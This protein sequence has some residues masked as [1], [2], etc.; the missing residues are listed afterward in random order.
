MIFAVSAILSICIHCYTIISSQQYIGE[1]V[2]SFLPYLILIATVFS[3]VSWYYVWYAWYKRAP[4]RKILWWTVVV[5]LHALIVKYYSELLIDQYP[6]IISQNQTPTLSGY[7]FLYANIYYKNENYSWLL[8]TIDQYQPDM[9]LLVEYAKQHDEVISP[10]LKQRYPYVSRYVGG[11]GYDGDVIYSKHKLTTIKH[12]SYPWSFSHVSITLNQKTIDFALI[13]TSAP[14][15]Y[16]FFQMR[17]DQLGLLSWLI[18][19]Y[20]QENSNLSNTTILLWDFNISPWSAY[21]HPFDQAM[22]QLGLQDISSDLTKTQYISK[23]PYTRCHE[24]MPIACSHIDHVRSN[25]SQL[26]LTQI[27]IPGSD[28]NGFI[29]T[30]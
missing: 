27:K 8:S 14:S 4:W 24:L 7:S 15:S 10:I 21:Y 30:L 22:R 25:S 5:I 16:H 26:H 23:M 17:N 29:G 2:I 18:S 20:I 13:H 6:T 3:L 1:L 19:D 9:I 28:H 12:T 11:K